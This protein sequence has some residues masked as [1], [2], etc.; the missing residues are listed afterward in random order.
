MAIIATTEAVRP[1]A[2]DSAARSSVAYEALLDRG[3]SLE[4]FATPPTEPEQGVATLLMDEY[5][6]RQEHAVFDVLVRFMDQELRRRV[7]A[8]IRRSGVSCEVDEVLQ[9][10][11]VNIFRYP[12]RFDASRPGA[13]GAWSSTITDNVIR[14]RFRGQG[15]RRVC[16][17]PIEL[18]EQF[19]DEQQ[20]APDRSAEHREEST[21][22]DSAFRL[23]L[24]CYMQAFAQ[25]SEREQHA[26]TMVEVE[27]MRYADLAPQMGIR[28][29]A[30]KMVI[31]RARKRVLGRMQRMMLRAAA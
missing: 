6:M 25:L 18:L 29:E 5:R 19:A 11:W 12:D 7:R 9:D 22:V 8:R 4:E 1:A 27:G 20:L 28:T 26:L 15:R 30:L 17:S 31:F 23:L 16:A 3:R 14:R 10:V 24:V 2:S 21:R 13:F